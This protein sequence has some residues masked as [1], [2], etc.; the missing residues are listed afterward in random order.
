MFSFHVSCIMYV[1]LIVS[2]KPHNQIRGE[3][4]SHQH[5]H[6]GTF[7]QITLY[8]GIA[9][10]CILL[11]GNVLYK[12]LFGSVLS[13]VHWTVSSA[14]WITLCKWSWLLQ[15]YYIVCE[16]NCSQYEK[17]ERCGSIKITI[18]CNAVKIA[19]SVWTEPCVH[20]HSSFKLNQASFKK[21][22]GF[23]K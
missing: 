23:F 7:R 2:C 3:P 20:K 19:L 21:E 11:H 4:V 17:G 8:Y 9:W 5:W 22:E 15:E 13:T 10:Y 18:F 12:V 1:S 16:H 14:N 6:L